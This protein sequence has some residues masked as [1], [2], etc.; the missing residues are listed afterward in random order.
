[1]AGAIQLTEVD[2][3]QIKLNLI[4]YLKST[5]QFTDYDFSGS[6]LQ[7]ILDLISYQAQLNAYSTN[8]IANESF[9]ASASIRD[10]VVANARAVGYTPFS[11]K[12]SS[13]ETTFQ[14][15][16]TSDDFPGGYPSFIEL[17]PG[18]LF[19]TGSGVANF[20]FN[21]IDPQTAPIGANGVCTF[22]NVNC[23]EGTYL[24]A[25]FTVNK[26]DFNQRFVLENKNIDTSTIRV[27]IQ[28]NPN[29]QNTVFFEQANNLV[30]VSDKSAVYWVEEVNDTHYEL[31]FGDGFFGRPLVDGSIINVTYLITEGGVA[32]GINPL[33]SF[34]YTGR[35]LASTGQVISQS[36]TIV[37]GSIT[38]GGSSIE[39]VDSVKFNAPKSYGAQNRAVIS[40][41]YETLIRQFYPAVDDIY[42]YGG[43]E[44]DIPEYGRV[45]VVIKPST[46]E[47]LSNTAKDSIIRS[48]NEYR[49]ASLQ[50]VIQDPEILYL[51]VVSE[52]F[53]NDK[54]TL[55]DAAGIVSAVEETLGGY[56]VSSNID[57]FG[58]SARFSRIVGAIDDADPSIIRNIT[59]LRMRRDFTVVT[60]TPASYE[61]CFEQAMKIDSTQSV[62]YSTGFQLIQ[63]GVN[64][65]RTYFFEDDSFGRIQTFYI[66]STGEKI[67]GNPNFGTV[68]YDKGEVMLGYTTPVVFANTVEPNSIIKVRAIPFGQDVVAKKTVYLG[69][70]LE[71]SNIQA[72]IDTNILSS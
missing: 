26:S 63:D 64:D 35:T 30:T 40:S 36:A 7:V 16:F 21:V 48:L 4:D 15:F 42:V 56:F 60:S 12:A 55:K 1:M 22:T 54:T 58:G 50:V 71:S 3:E 33:T 8:M 28:E 19:M 24:T 44:L 38:T 61:I 27:E 72:K 69:L 52:V 20:T 68:D 70:D 57:K 46:G 49:I 10:N 2:F 31:T 39:S 37:S 14:F 25:K 18:M 29:E 13:S 53:Y 59:S 6:N 43:E 32:N 11:A 65:G 45:F 62:V 23:Y 47:A 67:I 66:D 41:D 34:T 9:L 5:R 17:Q 51:E